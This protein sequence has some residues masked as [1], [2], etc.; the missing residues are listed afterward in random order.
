[1]M[2]RWS[3]FHRLAPLATVAALATAPAAA[4]PL[5][6]QAP[7]RGGLTYAI[8]HND[9]NVLEIRF[10]GVAIRG[11]HADD[12]QNA[13]AIDFQRPVD[14]TMFD[15][16]R[17]DAPLWISMS[18]CNSDNGVIRGTRPVTFLTRAENDGF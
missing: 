8:V 11:A 14:G 4:E 7:A 17:A 5:T 9:P 1:M 10:Y 2:G 12:S 13:L 15:R 18:T 6:Y 16:L 3:L